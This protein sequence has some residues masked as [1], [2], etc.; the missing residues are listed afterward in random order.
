[1]QHSDSPNCLWVPAPRPVTRASQ[2]AGYGKATAGGSPRHG[3]NE[4]P[5][6]PHGHARVSSPLIGQRPGSPPCYYD[7]PTAARRPTHM[8]ESSEQPL[9]TLRGAGVD[10]NSRKVARVVIGLC[11]ATMAVLVVVFTVAGAQ[12]NSQINSL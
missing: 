7:H 11:L 1:M 8:T 4:G 10:F 2:S 12:K 6:F 9:S 5:E 3:K